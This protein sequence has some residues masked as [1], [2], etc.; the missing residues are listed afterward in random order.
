MLYS[1]LL[2]ANLASRRG[3]VKKANIYLDG[4]CKT[5]AD[6]VNTGNLGKLTFGPGT[7]IVVIPS[8]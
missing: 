4:F 5:T 2:L 1:Q 6:C 3:G 7:K 8:K